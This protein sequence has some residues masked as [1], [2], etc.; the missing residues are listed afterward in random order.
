MNPIDATAMT[1]TVVATVP[2]SVPSI[3]ATAATT[4]L[5]PEGSASEP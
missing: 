3:Q 5:D 4:T 2:R 1:A